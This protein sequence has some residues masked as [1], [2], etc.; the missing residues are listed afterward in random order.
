MVANPISPLASSS[1]SRLMYSGDGLA[2]R[3]DIRFTT[4]PPLLQSSSNT[5]CESD[6]EH[7]VVVVYGIGYDSMSA[8]SIHA[9]RGSL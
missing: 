4:K 1:T 8:N 2:S 6:F 3:L 7:M 9:L 5:T